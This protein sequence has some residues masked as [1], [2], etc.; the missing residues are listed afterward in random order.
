[1][2]K[3]PKEIKLF[4]K[5]GTCLPLLSVFTIPSNIFTFIVLLLMALEL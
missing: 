4:L 5:L 2:S 1:M 3:S